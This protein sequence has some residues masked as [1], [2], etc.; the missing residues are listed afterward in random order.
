MAKVT[1]QDGSGGWGSAPGPPDLEA[2]SLSSALLGH[3]LEVGWRLCQGP[4][5]WE[6]DQGQALAGAFCIILNFLA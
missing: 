6:E 3:F 5:P 4:F 2:S 1:Q